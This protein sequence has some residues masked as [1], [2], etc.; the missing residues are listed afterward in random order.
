VYL[1]I[2]EAVGGPFDSKLPS[3]CSCC[4]GPFESKLPAHYSFCTGPLSQQ[5]IYLWFALQYIIWVN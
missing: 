3:S 4:W 5:R 2:S 1:H